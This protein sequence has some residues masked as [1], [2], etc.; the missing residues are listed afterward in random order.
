MT[1]S[2]LN[3]ICV[4]MCNRGYTGLM[5]LTLMRPAYD[6]WR[7]GEHHGPLRGSR[8]ASVGAIGALELDRP[9]EARGVREAVCRAGLIVETAGPRDEVVKP[10][11]A[12]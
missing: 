6:V 1:E 3:I 12:H 4:S 7:P 9:S 10:V 11:P 5:A 2:A 8:Q